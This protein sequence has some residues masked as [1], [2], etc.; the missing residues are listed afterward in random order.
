M[1]VDRW[2]MLRARLTL[3]LVSHRFVLSS[4]PSRRERSPEMSAQKLSETTTSFDQ[5]LRPPPLHPPPPL[6]LLLTT[7]TMTRSW[8]RLFSF[9]PPKAT[10]PARFSFA[11]LCLVAPSRSRVPSKVLRLAATASTFTSTA[12]W[13]RASLPAV[14]T[15]LRESTMVRPTTPFATSVTSATLSR[16]TMASLPSSVPTLASRC[17]A[18]TPSLAA[19][20]LCTWARTTLFLSLLALPAVVSRV[21]SLDT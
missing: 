16:L 14:T 21:V 3:S 5:N 12:M 8:R 18:P 7:T 6:P 20:S 11:S 2:T 17:R 13:R 1:P 9:A 15:T 19:R 10:S 4:S